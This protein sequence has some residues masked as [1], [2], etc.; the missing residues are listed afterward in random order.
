VDGEDNL[1]GLH[2]LIT[3]P[4]WELG[5]HCQYCIEAAVFSGDENGEAVKKGTKRATPEVIALASI[6]VEPGKV[7]D[8]LQEL[9][10]LPHFK[11][12]SVV[13]GDIDILLQLGGDSLTELLETALSE[14]QG[15][16]G[17]VHTSTAV[18]DGTR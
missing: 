13:T 6:V 2:D 1:S 11:G 3:G 18:A 10:H 4:L 5:V 16:E 7:G 8:V 15:I 9:G 14:L 12:A 17:I